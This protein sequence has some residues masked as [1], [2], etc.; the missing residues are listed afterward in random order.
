[1]KFLFQIFIFS[2]LSLGMTQ[3]VLAKSKLISNEMCKSLNQIVDTVV[4][5][6]TTQLL[7]RKKGKSRW[8][9]RNRPEY[10]L[11]MKVPGTMFTP[12][13]IETISFTGKKDHDLSSKTYSI[14]IPFKSAGRNKRNNTI[15]E[16][17]Y[18]VALKSCLKK[19]I[20]K[21]SKYGF[22]FD[23]NI[24]SNIR[25]NE[26]KQYK[27]VTSLSIVTPSQV[28]I[29]PLKNVSTK[30]LE[31]YQSIC[32]GIKQLVKKSSSD[33]KFLTSQTGKQ[34][35]KPIWIGEV[36]EMN[37]FKHKIR[38]LHAVGISKNKKRIYYK[39]YQKKHANLYMDQCLPS[40]WARTKVNNGIAYKHPDKSMR[41]IVTN[42]PVKKEN[43]IALAIGKEP[44]QY[45]GKWKMTIAD[46]KRKNERIKKKNERIK[47]QNEK[48]RKYNA[49][50][51]KRAEQQRAAMQRKLARERANRKSVPTISKT[52]Y[53]TCY[54]CNGTG[55]VHSK[56]TKEKVYQYVPTLPGDKNWQKGYTHYKHDTGRIHYRDGG[57]SRC[58]L[59]KGT[60][61]VKK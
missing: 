38:G 12:F 16:K 21:S 14:T 61:E 2:S 51:K 54:I 57:S 27:M 52:Q 15:D 28:T 32:N 25:T 29:K 39:H 17:K 45:N 55:Y 26:W 18:K 60:G 4:E 30:R 13:V 58:T 37:D 22:T 10:E 44:F 3:S 11:N 56:S 49:D 23:N 59:C 35:F 7:G 50:S 34:T 40:D 53:I 6:K 19:K 20:K 8:E 48:I 41:I 5:Q 47:E 36:E 42:T 43:V 33:R 24:R 46:I 1:M 9:Y 31:H